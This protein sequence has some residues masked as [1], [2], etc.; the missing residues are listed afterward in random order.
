MPAGSPVE[1]Q[2]AG[3]SLKEITVGGP[4]Q[5]AED[6]APGVEF[7]KAAPDSSFALLRGHMA[8][9]KV[10]NHAEVTL[11]LRV[12]HPALIFK[13]LPHGGPL[14][15]GGH[16]KEGH[17]GLDAIQKSQGL[18]KE[19]R[20]IGVQTEHEIQRVEEVPLRQAAQEVLVFLHRVLQLVDGRNGIL[21]NI[22]NADVDM[23]AA[24]FFSQIQEILV[25]G[26]IDGPEAAPF[27]VQGS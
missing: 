19:L 8:G 24:G 26:G 11:G 1:E 9:K 14:P 7:L 27:Y 4:Q 2:I 13:L 5:A 25:P 21:T 10:T 12:M 17:G 6:G 15:G 23:I 20:R 22:F 3:Q 18:F 16:V